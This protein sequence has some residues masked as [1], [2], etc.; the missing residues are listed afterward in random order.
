[1]Y[2]GGTTG[3]GSCTTA[4]DVVKPSK[5]SPFLSDHCDVTVM[6]IPRASLGDFS[7]HGSIAMDQSCCYSCNLLESGNF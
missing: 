1:M 3:L 6:C 7:C 4:F 2:D 5:H